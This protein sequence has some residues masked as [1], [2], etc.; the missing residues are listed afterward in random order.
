MKRK[1]TKIPNLGKTYRRL[2][3]SRVSSND[4]K[5]LRESTD[6]PMKLNG[7]PIDISSIELEDVNPN[8]WPDMVDAYIGYA[9]Y[10]DGTE[11]DGDELDELQ[12]IYR[13]EVGEMARE[14]AMGG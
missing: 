8:D 1:T 2:F 5:L 7:K 13:D 14:Q 11:L 12:D 10:T 6:S 9:Q 3:E 4:M